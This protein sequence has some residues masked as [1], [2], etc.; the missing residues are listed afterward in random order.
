MGMIEGDAGWTCLSG[1]HGQN[2][3]AG[4]RER[5]AELVVQ[6]AAHGQNDRVAV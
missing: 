4:D 1:F 5:W 2:G 3:F 6:I